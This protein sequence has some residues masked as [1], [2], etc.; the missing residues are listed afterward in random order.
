MADGEEALRKIQR[1]LIPDA[2][3]VLDWFH[4]T[5]RLTVLRQYVRGVVKQEKESDQ[6]TKDSIGHLLQNAWTSTKWKLWHGKVDDALERL[7]TLRQNALRVTTTYPRAD[8]FLHMIDDFRKYIVNNRALIPN[9]GELWRSGLP[10]TTASI[11]SL[12]NSLIGR[13]FSKKQQM[14]W[15]PR[16]AHMLLQVRV[17]AANGDLPSTFQRWYPD[18]PVADHNASD[19]VEQVGIAA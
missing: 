5:M 10:I 14:Q 6:Y 4:I 16:G 1:D 9:Y 18:F 3:H 19:A 12:V 17:R 2:E 13:R 8:G 15:T 11:E 7:S